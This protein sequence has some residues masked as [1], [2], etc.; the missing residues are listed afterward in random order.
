M[1]YADTERELASD[2]RTRG[3]WEFV[4]RPVGYQVDRIE[5]PDLLIPLVQKAHV[6]R[7]GWSL[8]VSLINGREAAGSIV[9]GGVRYLW[10]VCSS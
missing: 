9:G 8:T 4:V 10:S 2:I 5:T 6:E 3:H 7:S 1:S